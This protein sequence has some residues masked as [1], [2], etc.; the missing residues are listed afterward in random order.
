MGV[1]WG[2]VHGGAKGLPDVLS[3]QGHANEFSEEG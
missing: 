2:Q 3:I 1:D